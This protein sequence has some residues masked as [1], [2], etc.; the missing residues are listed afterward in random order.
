ML[1]VGWGLTF[2][3]SSVL[4]ERQPSVSPPRRDWC[5]SPRWLFWRHSWLP[6][7]GAECSPPCRSWCIH[8]R[9]G[10]E[11]TGLSCHCPSPQQQSLYCYPCRRQQTVKIITTGFRFQFGRDKKKQIIIHDTKAAS[12]GQNVLPGYRNEC[13]PHLYQYPPTTWLHNG[14]SRDHQC[15]TP[16]G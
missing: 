3:I 4:L 8:P 9:V 7:V 5:R 1:Q 16:T 11:S 10:T 14:D 15:N 12:S 2:H 13:C 6:L